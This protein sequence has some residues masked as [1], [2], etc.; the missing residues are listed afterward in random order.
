MFLYTSRVSEHLRFSSSFV[1]K[2]NFFSYSEGF[3]LFYFF[4]QK[5]HF[6]FRSFED[7]SESLGSICAENCNF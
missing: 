5:K 6:H 2:Q 4:A 7:V 3:I 1:K